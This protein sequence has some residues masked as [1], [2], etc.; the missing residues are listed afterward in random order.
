MPATIFLTVKTI[1]DLD[2][3]GN[4]TQLSL[5]Q[6]INRANRV[7]VGDETVIDFAL[8]RS[9]TI[10]LFEQLPTLTRKVSINGTI[11]I[12][13]VDGGPQTEDKVTVARNP[14]YANFETFRLFEVAN[15]ST[16][17]LSNLRLAGGASDGDGGAIKNEG[18]LTLTG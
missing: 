12:P 11:V 13:G 7:D 1:S 6:A 18:D 17:S 15:T 10:S 2:G 9:Q 14:A 4:I 16:A 5:R 8:P 3:L